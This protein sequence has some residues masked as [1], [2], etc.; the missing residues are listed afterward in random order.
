[1]EI[2]KQKVKEANNIIGKPGIVHGNK[3]TDGD[4]VINILDCEPYNKHK[5]G[6]IH[7]IAAKA[8][9][10]IGAKKTAEK[11]RQAEYKSDERKARQ[12]NQAI[13]EAKATG[14]TDKQIYERKQEAKKYKYEKEKEIQMASRDAYYESKKKQAIINATEKGKGGGFLNTFINQPNKKGVVTGKLQRRKVVSYK[15][16]KGGKYKKVVSYKTTGTRASAPAQPKP[17][18]MPN[19]FGG[20]S[21]GNSA[22]IPQLFTSNRGKERQYKMPKIF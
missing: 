4:G 11:I 8:A 13:D 5:Q 22:Q 21:S 6:M 14:Q 1:M 20:N 17:Y 2:I 16:M 12:Y 19:I 15:K 7:N 18:V 10:L 9:N 3:D